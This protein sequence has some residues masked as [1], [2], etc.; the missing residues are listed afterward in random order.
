[1]VGFV[2]WLAGSFVKTITTQG[3]FSLVLKNRCI[4]K[5]HDRTFTATE[6]FLT[7]P[8]YSLVLSTTRTPVT[9]ANP[10]NLF[11]VLHP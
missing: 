5:W 11:I 9:C 7:V 1:M 4:D 10:L 2:G 3:N 8:I 6:L